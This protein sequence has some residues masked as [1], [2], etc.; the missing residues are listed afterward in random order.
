MTL[1]LIMFLQVSCLFP[2]LHVVKFSNGVT[3]VDWRSIQGHL[4]HWSSLS[5][6]SGGLL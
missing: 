3:L 6:A 2:G 1:P 5:G 4:E